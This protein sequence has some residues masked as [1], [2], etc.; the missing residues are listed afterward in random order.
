MSQI[1]KVNIKGL[2]QLKIGSF[3]MLFS[4]NNEHS[5]LGV[6]RG[7]RPPSVGLQK[8]HHLLGNNKNLINT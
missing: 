5:V 7:T 4:L 1:L 2:F 6:G 8:A 3:I